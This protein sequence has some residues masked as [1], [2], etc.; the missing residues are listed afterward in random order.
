MERKNKK[1]AEAAL[2]M[3]TESLSASELSRVMGLSDVRDAVKALD[4][5]VKEFNS[6]DTALEVIKT[7]EGN[8][9]MQVRREFLPRVK[10]L[11]T[12][13]DLPK[14]VLRTLSVIAFKQPIKQSVVAKLRGNK[15]YE[16]VK[17]LEDQ[18][19]IKRQ[20]SGHTFVLETT[21]KFSDYFQ[22]PEDSSLEQ[23]LTGENPLNSPG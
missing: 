2:F 16:H 10:H 20:K 9:R 22:L 21:R 6:R 7:S 8:Y 17:E 23:A 12:S 13:V 5:L 15:A 14:S 11:A 18:G 4:E 19:F 1:L 3:S